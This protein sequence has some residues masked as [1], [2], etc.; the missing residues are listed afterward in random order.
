MTK[1]MEQIYE[2]LVRSLLTLPLSQNLYVFG[3]P[4]ELDPYFID[5]VVSY[6]IFEYIKYAFD[7]NA[8][9]YPLRHFLIEKTDDE[10]MLQSRILKYVLKY[11][12]KEIKKLHIHLPK[13]HKYSEVDMRTI[14]RRLESASRLSPLMT[15]Y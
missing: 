7:M 10:R 11:K 14:A 3:G 13:D 5:L 4:E 9:E 8:K 6:V 15:I 2:S 1:K 12:K